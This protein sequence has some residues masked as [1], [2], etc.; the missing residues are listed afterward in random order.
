[1]I[2]QSAA[3]ISVYEDD[4]QGVDLL[5]VTL[6]Q[7]SWKDAINELIVYLIDA[8][9]SPALAAGL[10]VYEGPAEEP[11][12]WRREGVRSDGLKEVLAT[13]RAMFKGMRY[14]EILLGERYLVRLVYHPNKPYQALRLA[15]DAL[16]AEAGLDDDRKLA[17]YMALALASLL[18]RVPA[19]GLREQEYAWAGVLW[20]VTGLLGFRAA[21]WAIEHEDDLE[22]EKTPYRKVERRVL[23]AVKQGRPLR[24]PKIRVVEMLRLFAEIGEIAWQPEVLRRWSKQGGGTIESLHSDPG[25]APLELEAA[26][27]LALALKGIR[28]KPVR[29]AIPLDDGRV[30]WLRVQPG[31]HVAL[32][33]GQALTL[34]WGEID[35]R[36]LTWLV[37]DDLPLRGTAFLPN[38]T[39]LFLEEPPE[40]VQEDLLGQVALRAVR[41]ARERQ[42]YVP[43]GQGFLLGLSGVAPRA[44]QAAG[45]EALAVWADTKGL[46]GRVIAPE[47]PSDGVVFRW[48]PQEQF[49][50]R[51]YPLFMGRWARAILDVISAMLWLDLVTARESLQEAREGGRKRRS[52]R[53]RRRADE[54]RPEMPATPSARVR[55]LPRRFARGARWVRW[56]TGD[57]HR[58]MRSPHWVMGH[59]RRLPPGRKRTKEAER[60][61]EDYGVLLPEDK[62]ATFVRPHIRGGE[63]EAGQEGKAP[64]VQSRGLMTLLS[65]FHEETKKEG[66]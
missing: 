45:V 5:R 51:M 21:T 25:D 43:A 60:L 57:E 56:G 17:L 27:A 28:G 18:P 26:A 50:A 55:R 40:P 7:G 30:R 49:D 44:L 64:K 46:W 66:A 65:L 63:L 58:A 23:D 29:A 20:W 19:R 1:M 39:F 14:R 4:F 10:R 6:R 42:R 36:A 48:I 35:D 34:T 13:R 47:A 61:A 37:G 32:A 53:R 11:P 62:G 31:Q 16:R 15:E 54:G 24:V 33:F 2:H 52:R 41:E 9:A 59:I 22:G 8:A 38:Q 3:G 12:L